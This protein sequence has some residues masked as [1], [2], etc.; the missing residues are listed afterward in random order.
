MDGSVE[1]DWDCGDDDG[2]GG[3]AR[4]SLPIARTMVDGRVSPMSLGALQGGRLVV[5]SWSMPT[6][7]RT[8]TMIMTRLR[9]LSV[10]HMSGVMDMVPDKGIPKYILFYF[11]DDKIKSLKKNKTNIQIFA[12][13]FDFR[14]P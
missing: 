9:E 12:L 11:I 7:M 2:D 5:R 4:C 13:W 14:C 10:W 3:H 1:L 8:H 6:L